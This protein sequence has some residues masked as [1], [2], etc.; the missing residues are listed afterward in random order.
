VWTKIKSSLQPGKKLW[1][2]RRAFKP[3]GGRRY[4]PHKFR[5]FTL[6]LCYSLFSL[7]LW[8]WTE[9]TEAPVDTDPPP[10][11]PPPFRRP[12]PLPPPSLP[13]G[14]LFSQSPAPPV[15]FF[16][17]ACVPVPVLF[18]CFFCSC[19]CLH[20]D[21][22]SGGSD[23]SRTQVLGGCHQYTKKYQRASR[24]AMNVDAPVAQDNFFGETK[25]NVSLPLRC[26]RAEGT[27]GMDGPPPQFRAQAEL[28]AFSRQAQILFS[29]RGINIKDLFPHDP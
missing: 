5:T 9:G 3:F 21:E 18:S 1:F 26:A 19:F 15:R 4:H 8:R 23:I 10:L 11:V 22:L 27:G 2:R 16:G 13:V 6:T 17:P 14:R 25:E 12:H 20:R 29:A 28:R 24:T 7:V